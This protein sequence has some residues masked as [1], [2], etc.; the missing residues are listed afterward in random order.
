MTSLI[1]ENSSTESEMIISLFMALFYGKSSN[2]RKIL[3]N[4]V[5]NIVGIY[6]QE[7]IKEN[8][9]G[10]LDRGKSILSDV[11][12]KL[13]DIINKIDGDVLRNDIIKLYSFMIDIFNVEK[14]KIKDIKDNNNIIFLSHIDMKLENEY[15]CEHKIFKI[16]DLFKKWLTNDG[17][18]LYIINYPNIVGVHIDRTKCDKISID[19]QK[20]IYPHDHDLLND[21]KWEFHSAVCCNSK[22]HYY[23]FAIVMGK[24]FLFDCNLVPCIK[25]IF[26]NDEKIVKNLKNDVILLIY[27]NC[28]NN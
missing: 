20:R 4:N 9:I 28:T 1:I 14:I 24:W 19:I 8:F 15:N 10:K 13:I 23:S 27:N 12:D 21:I 25:E 18:Q 26:M 6:F 22:G 2:I 5:D 3:N 17:S 7:F 16:N 11:I